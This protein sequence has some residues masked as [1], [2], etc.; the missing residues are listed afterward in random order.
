MYGLLMM[1]LYADEI[2]DGRK[3]NDARLYPTDKRGTIAIVDS[4]SFKVYGTAELT[5]IREITYEEF[6]RW[7]QVGPFENTPIAPYSEGKTCYSYELSN[8][9][10]LPV[11]YRL[12][13]DESARMWVEIPE[14]I[15]RNFFAQSTLF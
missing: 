9:K 1:K 13:K 12:P 3:N 10:R 11:P 4:T 14:R 8:V 5:G 6:V 15:S 2:L 7:H